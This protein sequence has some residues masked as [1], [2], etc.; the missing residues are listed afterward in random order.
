MENDQA[1]LSHSMQRVIALHDV[2]GHPSSTDNAVAVAGRDGA[3]TAG[4]VAA[5]IIV[6]QILGPEVSV[7][8]R[9][10]SILV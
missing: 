5:P 10:R 8:D 4:S 3:Q 9:D 6:T 7:K 1:D 2:N